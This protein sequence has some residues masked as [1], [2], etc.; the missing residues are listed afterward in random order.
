MIA[1]HPSLAR[2][3]RLAFGLLLFGVHLSSSAFNCGSN[4]ST[5]ALLNADGTIAGVRCVFIQSLA[6]NAIGEA[7][8]EIRWY[9][10]GQSPGQSYRQIGYASSYYVKPVSSYSSA[11]MYI[12]GN[13]ETRSGQV[14]GLPVPSV[15]G[16]VSPPETIAF[17]APWNETWRLLIFADYTPLAPPNTCGDGLDTFEVRA[18]KTSG[19]GLGP[20]VG[21]R[22]LWRPFFSGGQW[23]GVGQWPGQQP[24]RHLG[25]RYDVYP[26]GDALD[27]CEGTCKKVPPNSLKFSDAGPNYDGFRVTGAWNEY[28]IRPGT[29]TEPDPLPPACKQRPNLPQCNPV[30]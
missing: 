19:R 12:S 26:V 7:D 2:T 16:T 5:Y 15:S 27:I 10:E 30:R 8:F 22:C 14:A 11:A 9:G 18:R 20:V 4:H 1:W 25:I 3:R 28:W 29:Y 6:K 13:G 17:G 23:Y 24:Y 21:F